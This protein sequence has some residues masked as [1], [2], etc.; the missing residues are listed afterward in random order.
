MSGATPATRGQGSFALSGLSS[1]QAQ[2]PPRRG[3]GQGPQG[4]V[5]TRVAEGARQGGAGRLSGEQCPGH[6]VRQAAPSSVGL[7]SA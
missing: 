1:H 7:A 6:E 3:A 2:D 4:G 5:Q